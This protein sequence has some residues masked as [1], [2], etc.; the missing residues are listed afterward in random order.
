MFG[1]FRHWL[2]RP[3]HRAIVADQVRSGEPAAVRAT[4]ER[5]R[6]EGWS[7]RRIWRALTRIHRD[8]VALML[9][10]RRPFDREAYARALG[11][12]GRPD[13]GGAA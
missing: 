11:A 1:W 13:K 5:L 3:S 9:E 7:E 2:A 4:L 12:L 6:A 10:R 8:A